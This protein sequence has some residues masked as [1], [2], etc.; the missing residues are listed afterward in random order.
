MEKNKSYLET[1]ADSWVFKSFTKTGEFI[2]KWTMFSIGLIIYSLVMY[3]IW[4]GNFIADKIDNK[5][6][7][8]KHGNGNSTHN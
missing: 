1:Y 8:K 4:L 6:E 2:G 5:K 7:A 3:G